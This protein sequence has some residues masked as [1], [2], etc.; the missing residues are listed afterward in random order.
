[1]PARPQVPD[2]KRGPLQAFSYDLRELGEGKVSIPWIAVHEDTIV[3]RAALYAALSGTRLPTAET[4][5]TLLRWWAGKPADELVEL[6]N[7]W[8]HPWDWIDR[9]PQQHEGR[10]LADE[11]LARYRRVSQ[12]VRR[13]RGPLIKVAPV[14]IRIPEE[15]QIFI[16]ELRGLIEMTGLKTQMWLLFGSDATRVERYLAGEAIPTERSCLMLDNR[17]SPFFPEGDIPPVGVRL[18][19]AAQSARAGRVRARRLARE[20]KASS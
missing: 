12:Q 18:W 15:Q 13:D 14:G 2:P 5:S 6:Q 10:R 3:S 4:V 11:W 7:D 17:L 9:L 8:P 20:S 16:A 1:M 19:N